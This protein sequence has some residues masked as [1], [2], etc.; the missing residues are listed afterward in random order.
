MRFTKHHGL[1]N[2]FLVVLDLD[3][4]QPVSPAL[5]R[6]VCDRHRGIGADGVLRVTGGRRVGDIDCDVTMELLNADGGR[7]EM[8]GNGISC[9]VQAVRHTGVSST[10]R[11]VVATDAGSRAVTA[12]G[13]D[14]PRVD[15]MTVDMGPAKVVD[16]DRDWLGVT[17]AH[18]AQV[19]V[20]NP[21]VVL[22]V[23]ELAAIDLEALGQ[24]ANDLVPGGV[25]VEV[26]T[27]SGADEAITM[28]VY[29][30]GV[31]LTEACG[32]GACAVAAAVVHWGV[33]PSPVRVRQPGGSTD[34]TVGDT[35]GYTVDVT[36]VATIDFAWTAHD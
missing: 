2:D 32:T 12:Y 21:H 18:V 23:D 6:A 10:D 7:A 4:T 34:V 20:G 19:D 35:L 5:A 16:V 26:C 8:S 13:T 28:A 1:G 24:L 22:D 29:E 17:A 30:R 15:R 31:G 36:Y 11:I 33:V 14:D 9:M 25:N 3:D 27:R